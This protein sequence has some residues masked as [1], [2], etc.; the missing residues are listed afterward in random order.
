ME[1]PEEE[2]GR[3]GAG[4]GD[5][6]LSTRLSRKVIRRQNRLLVE[7]AMGR[8]WN[9]RAAREP[10]DPDTADLYSRIWRGAIARG[11]VAGAVLG[12]GSA[13]V[14]LLGRFANLDSVRGS[15]LGTRPASVLLAVV[16]LLI[17][18]GVICLRREPVPAWRRHLADLFAV[19]T[20]VLA[21]LSLVSQVAPAVGTDWLTGEIL[22]DSSL[23]TLAFSVLLGV[24]LLTTDR[25]LPGGVWSHRIAPLLWLVVLA[26][27]L[28]RGYR[29]SGP[30]GIMSADLSVLGLVGMGGL[31]FAYL[32]LRPGKGMAGFMIADGPGPAMARM[33]APVI[34]A[35]PVAMAIGRGASRPEAG[36]GG[37]ALMQLGSEMAVMVALAAVVT[38]ASRR[39]QVYYG[40]WRRANDELSEQA[41]VLSAM[42]EGVAVMRITDNE[43]VLTNPQFD[44]MHGYEPGS[45]AGQPVET[46]MPDDPTP[47][48]IKRQEEIGQALIEKG[49]AEFETRALRRDGSIIWCRTRSILTE[50]P[51]HGPVL[52]MVRSDITAEHDAKTAGMAA[53]T[54]FREVFEQSPIGLA[55]VHPEGRFERVN[56]SFEEL[57]GYSAGELEQMT[58]GDIT[59]PDDLARDLELTG[60]MFAGR[61]GGFE[62]EKRYIRKDGSIVRVELSAV[63]LRDGDGAGSLALSMIQ[64]VTERHE[65]GRKLRFLADH[66]PLT[67]LFNRRRFEK[68]L[69]GVATGSNGAEGRGLAVMMIDL[70]NFKYINDHFGHTVGDRLIIRTGEVLRKRLRGGDVLARQGGDEFVILLCDIPPEKALPVALELVAEIEADARIEGPGF[71]ARTT[72]SIGVAVCPNPGPGD[73]ERLIQEADI[74]MYE[75]KDA[76]RNGARIYDS[77][78]PSEMSRG[79]DWHT[80]I[81]DALDR[82][83]FTLAA[84]PL[85][86]L[87]GESES[88]FELF[89]RLSDEG[90]PVI[91][92]A[93]F[94]PVAERHNLIGEIDRWVVTQAIRLLARC[95]PA[96]APRLF[97]NLS[98]QSVGDMDVLALIKRELAETEVDPGRLVFEVTETSAIAN[99][100]RAQKF[101][102]ALGEMG[103][104]TALDDFGA[105]FAS[106]YYLKHISSRFVKIDGEFIRNLAGEPTSQLLVKALADLSRGLGKQTVAEHVEDARALELLT[107]YG[108]D[109]VQGFLFGQPKAATVSFLTSDACLAGRVRAALG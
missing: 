108:V 12:L 80:R 42:A 34:V 56:R 17:G 14:I 104:D 25:E 74:A 16:M 4:A 32:V 69:T 67:G 77:S 2:A 46:V 86:S 6:R 57:V 97:V 29:I 39:L 49:T 102:A 44:L 48:E 54:R 89:L 15:L 53:E 100:D 98:G 38:V 72:S 75:V 76:G 83:G 37:S 40:E 73:P 65:L 21:I 31:G 58:F 95:G 90:G 8:I 13:G 3:D 81:R 18:A 7:R 47:D 19:G 87:R 66:D 22:H 20:I 43:L 101:T 61:S 5:R 60:E 91:G 96:Q 88:Q 70:D 27:L 23:T 68:E 11:A 64:D 1:D 85:V 9:S 41:R 10:G 109:L 62:M 30:D 35:I 99:I 106:F 26:G 93:A 79:I 107:G 103:C 105:G 78:Q 63:M 24:G 71:L 51:R 84:Q 52:I 55:L 33:L 50:D 45:L 92:P 36:G 59:H 94:L 28:T 82:E